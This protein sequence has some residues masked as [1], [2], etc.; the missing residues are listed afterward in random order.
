[1]NS[2]IHLSIPDILSFLIIYQSFLFTIILKAKPE[3]KNYFSILSLFT[4]CIGLNF[5]NIILISQGLIDPK[6]NFGISF[7][8]AYGPL[9]YLYT[10]VI[11]GSGSSIRSEGLIHF[12]PMLVTLVFLITD[13]KQIVF[14]HQMAISI[15]VISHFA[16]YFLLSLKAINRFSQNV[17][18]HFSSIETRSLN[19]WRAAL[20]IF[21]ALLLFS[22]LD[23][24][25]NLQFKFQSYFLILLYGSVLIFVNL[26]FYR[27]ISRPDML[28][29]LKG[30]SYK[31]RTPRMEL[32]KYLDHIKGRVEIEKLF[33]D[34][35]LTLVAL[36]NYV[37]LPSKLV[38]EAIH[39][40]GSQNFYEFIND[41]RLEYAKKLLVDKRIARHRINEIMYDSGFRSK[42]TFNDIFKRKV[43]T[44]PNNFR[45]LNQK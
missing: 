5:L 24:L 6:L 30:Q 36:S 20:L 33:L 10:N 25:L 38:S 14:H 16:V 34:P 45:K 27:G 44:T 31:A 29:A 1:M 42:S 37:R 11:T 8:L 9:C 43:G 2:V 28:K 21:G 19:W 41:Y 18:F 23:V 39:S 17:K 15:V 40:N 22:I 12:I 4:F 3:G 13:T 32:M 7:G 35:D 26:I